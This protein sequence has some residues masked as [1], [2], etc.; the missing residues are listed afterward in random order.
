MDEKYGNVYMDFGD[1]ISVKSFISTMIGGPLD[2]NVRNPAMEQ[3]QILHLGY[4]IVDR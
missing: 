4:N 3:E 2:L 1:P